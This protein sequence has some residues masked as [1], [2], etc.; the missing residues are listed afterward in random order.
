M[1]SAPVAAKKRDSGP[2][3]AFNPKK[4]LIKFAFPGLIL[5]VLSSFVLMPTLLKACSSLVHMDSHGMR[6]FFRQSGI[7]GPL[8]SIFLLGVQS[9]IVPLPS[10]VITLANAYVYGWFYG[11]AITWAGTLLGASICF[12]LA[13]L[14]G[15]PFVER[16]V[17]KKKL[18]KS[19]EFI[20]RYGKYTI[21]ICRLLPFIPLDP[22]S[23]IAGLSNMKFKTFIG[24]TAIA[25]IPVLAMYS[26][27]GENLPN[28]IQV[29]KLLLLLLFQYP[30]DPITDADF[31]D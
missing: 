7:K 4:I 3:R 1:P 24:A 16:M 20:E 30:Y 22:V 27:F 18:E 29:G 14:Y 2:G 9:V 21:V 12:G 23:Y 6:E 13:R 10:L 26:Y 25:Q 8:V 5:I 11:A 19:S 17:G 31:L 15:R 28:V